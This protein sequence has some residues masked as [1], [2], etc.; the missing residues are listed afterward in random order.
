MLEKDPS[1]RPQTP[2]E[3]ARELLPFCKHNTLER[4]AT[5]STPL[6]EHADLLLA[7]QQDS[8][9]AGTTD[10]IGRP[11]VPGMATV[12]YSNPARRQRRIPWWAVTAGALFL[13]AGVVGGLSYYGVEAG[14]SDSVQPTTPTTWRNLV[15]GKWEELLDQPPLEKQW[16]KDKESKWEFDQGN[17][18]VSLKSTDWGMLELAAFDAEAFDIEATFSQINWVG[19]TG[20]YFR[21]G[22]E[23]IEGTRWYCGDFLTLGNFQ[24]TKPTEPASLNI[25]ELRRHVDTGGFYSLYI[26]AADIT[27]Q[28]RHGEHCLAFTVESAR[29]TNLRW[30]GQ[31]VSTRLEYPLPKCPQPAGQFAVGV[32]VEES[33]TLFRSVNVR[34]HSPAG[35]IP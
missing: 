14:P 6:S 16:P 10:F 13:L 33:A 8:A 7:S 23:R 31:P 26:D 12:S 1:H 4:I 20:V 32:L 2:V 19:G 29:L 17:R 9:K 22:E 24:H 34:I 11:A 18:Q 25:G 5:R 30:D 27:K 28:P 35:T 15:P 21:R 3:V